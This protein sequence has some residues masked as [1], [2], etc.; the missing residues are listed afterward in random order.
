MAWLPVSVSG[1]WLC[2]GKPSS[3]ST[4]LL[5]AKN[6]MKP[7]LNVAFFLSYYSK[8]H[9]LF[10][11][12]TQ[13]HFLLKRS[14][15]LS[16]DIGTSDLEQRPARWP[17][18]GCHIHNPLPGTGNI[19]AGF[20][21]CPHDALGPAVPTVGTHLRMWDPQ[22]GQPCAPTQSQLPQKHAS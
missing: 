11:H 3:F 19:S 14:F 7:E 21:R 22:S 2:C 4:V 17:S 9:K 15:L 8:H 18:G 20:S 10:T 13:P 6:M 1:T 16:P 5:I 12:E